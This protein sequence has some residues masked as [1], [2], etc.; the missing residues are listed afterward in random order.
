MFK[1]VNKTDVFHS[2]YYSYEEHFTLYLIF[3]E[4]ET[5]SLFSRLDG[6]ENFNLSPLSLFYALSNAQFSGEYFP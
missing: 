5:T 1:N 6:V 2:Q 4:F 3:Y